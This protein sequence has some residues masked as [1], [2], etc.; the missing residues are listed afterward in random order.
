MRIYQEVVRSIALVVVCLTGSAAF[1]QGYPIKPIRLIVP[2]SPGGASDIVARI[3]APGLSEYLGQ[4][5]V[6]DNRG[7]AAGIVGTAIA[8]EALADGYTILLAPSSHAI[9]QSLHDKLPYHAINS[10]DPIILLDSAPFVVAVH[11]S[12]PMRSVDDLLKLAKAKPKE[13]LYPS[14]GIGSGSH[15]AGELF[16]AMAHV[17][18]RHVP[19]KGI[20]PSIIDLIAGRVQL[21]FS[22]PLPIMP[23]VKMGKVVMIAQTGSGP[24]AQMPGVP[25]IATVV[26]GYKAISWHGILAPSGTPKQIVARLNAGLNAVLK[27]SQITQN[28]SKQGL[29]PGGGTSTQLVEYIAADVEKFSKVIKSLGINARNL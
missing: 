3:V 9:N 26:P 11:P 1:A 4:Q 29:E 8:A 7:G 18:I 15:L 28:L 12:L 16:A 23:H 10:F 22:P 2:F 19:Y 21:V 24:S 6:V 25:A 20:G 14:G 5:V 27:Q 17:E 13:L